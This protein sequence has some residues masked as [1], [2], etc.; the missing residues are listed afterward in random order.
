MFSWADASVSTQHIASGFDQEAAAVLMARIVMYRAETEDG[1]D[2]LRWLDRM[3]I[4]LV[5]TQRT[6]LCCMS[7]AWF[8]HSSNT[9]S[10]IY[11]CQ[12]IY[13]LDMRQT[14]VSYYLTIF[15]KLCD[16]ETDCWNI[17]LKLVFYCWTI[18]GIVLTLLL[19]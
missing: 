16:Y 12:K 7:E 1:P 13:V 2:A 14:H 17:N 10:D 5:S 19:T 6:C 3:L 15:Y 8:F 18:E 9:I 11:W 4:R